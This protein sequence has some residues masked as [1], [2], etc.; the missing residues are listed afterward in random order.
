MLLA[1]PFS[2]PIKTD[3][4][5]TPTVKRIVTAPFDGQL[6]KTFVEPGDQ[7]EEGQI[8]GN[9]ESRELLLKEA[10]LTAGRE[11]ALKQ[12]DKAM[13]DEGEGLDFA[14]AQLAQFEAQRIGE[15]LML[16]KRRLAFLKFDLL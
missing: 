2:Y 15:E 7:V 6:R 10:E 11:R 9:L 3:C 5:I 1:W 14:A 13:T 12:R 8:L 4:Q 16:V